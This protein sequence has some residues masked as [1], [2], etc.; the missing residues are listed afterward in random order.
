M[1][2]THPGRPIALG[3]GLARKDTTPMSAPDETGAIQ[4][5]IVSAV[6]LADSFHDYMRT[7]AEEE[8][9]DGGL[10]MA[11]QGQ[12]ILEATTEDEIWDADMIGTVQARDCIGMEV[13]VHDIRSVISN[14]EDIE[15][16]HGYYISCN[17]TCNSAPQEILAKTGVTIGQ[18][19]V[20]QTGADLIT[21]KLRS[22][23]AR[24]MLPITGVISGTT[25]RKGTVLRFTKPPVRAIAGKSA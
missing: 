10:I 16:G 14:R 12:K 2:H 8:S 4:P 5:R 15:G 24:D 13:T 23:E 18:E 21:Y 17:A 22:F 11:T 9:G 1:H 7:R 19:F 20:L 3:V 6:A 25:T